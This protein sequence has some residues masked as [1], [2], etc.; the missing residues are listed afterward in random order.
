MKKPSA[1]W[2]ALT[3]AEITSVLPVPSL[4]C[5]IT[6]GLGFFHISQRHKYTQTVNLQKTFKIYGVNERVCREKGLA[7]RVN[8]RLSETMFYEVK[9]KLYTYFFESIIYP[10]GKT[11][12]GEEFTNNWSETT[13]KKAGKD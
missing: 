3:V 6:S 9:A 11:Y 8:S 2:F 13:K 5:T 4:K 10:T 1:A 7:V 12:R